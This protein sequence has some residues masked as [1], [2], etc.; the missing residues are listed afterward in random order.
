MKPQRIVFALV[1]IVFLI[2]GTLRQLWPQ[3]RASISSKDR[4]GHAPGVVLPS[5]R[6]VLRGDLLNSFGRHSCRGRVDSLYRWGY[7]G[8]ESVA[9]GIRYGTSL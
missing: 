9:R 1:G 6:N 5:H 2:A 4:R 7:G 3:P 8:G